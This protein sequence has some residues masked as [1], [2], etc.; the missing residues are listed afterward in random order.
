M[1]DIRTTT[2]EFTV[3]GSLS[4]VKKEIETS[5]PIYELQES[6]QFLTKKIDELI[7]EVN[8]LKNQ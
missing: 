3:S 1:T 8:V 2:E 7:T 6:I 5:E 4:E